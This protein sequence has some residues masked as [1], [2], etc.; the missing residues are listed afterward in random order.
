MTLRSAL[1]LVALTATSSAAQRVSFPSFTGPGAATVRNQLVSTACDTAECVPATKTTTSGK[2]DWKKA[3][4]ESVEFFVTGSVVKKGKKVSLDLFVFNKAG[5][6]KARKNFPLEK[7]GSLSAKNLQAAMDLMSGAFGAKRAAPPPDPV[8]PPPDEVKPP[9]KENGR[10]EPSP[11]PDPPPPEKR[12]AEPEEKRG[13]D[14]APPPTSKPR[15]PKFLVIDAGAEVLN[16]RLDYSQVATSNLRRYDL[17]IYGQLALGVEFY[18]LAL[19]RDDL[20]AGLGV[21]FG[22]ALAPWLQSRLSSI[23]DPFPTSATR[24]DAGVRFSISPIKSFAL[25]LAPY[26]GVRAQRFTVG[27]LPDGTRLNGLP[28]IGFVGLRVGLAVDVPLVPRILN[29]WGKFGI[30]PVFSSG[31]IISPAYFPNGSAF[32]IEASVGLS[33]GVL[34]FLQIRASFEFQRYGL[35]FTTQPTDAYVA[36][37]AS[38]TYLG[39]KAVAR[40]SF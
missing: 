33:V 8:K 25:N 36:A 5:A 18:P 9:L 31:E 15:K 6:P 35:T 29:L 40:V 22:L 21:E 26:L 7:N 2:P 4:K 34:P 30:V 28:N 37:G 20:L 39:G 12:T 14:P 24:I 19:I 1:A 10:K 3:K 23:P 32:G 17:P 38:D 27:A 13:E 11:P 16:R